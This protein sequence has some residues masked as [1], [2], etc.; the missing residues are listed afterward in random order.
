V[1]LTSPVGIQISLDA[2]SILNG[3]LHAKM[4]RTVCTRN[5]GPS[6]SLERLFNSG[7]TERRLHQNRQRKNGRPERAAISSNL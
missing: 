6:R 7:I 3:S 5:T 4:H 1:I 2:S